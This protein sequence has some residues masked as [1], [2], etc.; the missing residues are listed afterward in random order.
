MIVKILLVTLLMVAGCSQSSHT[1]TTTPPGNSNHQDPT[2]AGEQPDVNPIQALKIYDGTSNS[3]NKL[4]AVNVEPGKLFFDFDYTPAQDE[5]LVLVY[6]SVKSTLIGCANSDIGWDFT[7]HQKK[8][9]GKIDLSTYK[10]LGSAP[11]EVIQGTPYFVRASLNI[12]KSCL[13]MAYSF[14]IK[15]SN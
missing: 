3:L 8:S 7:L 9:D 14:I 4:Q 11:T 1:E 15:S 10:G 2:P 13:G 5:A 12:R 6:N